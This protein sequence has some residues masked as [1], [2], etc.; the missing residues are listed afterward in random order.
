LS[1]AR[2]GG[3][4]R[5][6]PLGVA[7]RQGEGEVVEEE[8]VG[9]QPVLVAGDVADAAGDLELAAPGPG[10]PLLVDGE[11]DDALPVVADQGEH[12][13]AAGPAVLEVDGVD[14]APPRIGL[15]RPSDHGRVCRV[16][17]QRC[18]DGLLERLDGG[19][20]L[21]GLVAPLGEGDADIQ[22]MGPALDLTAGHPDDPLVVVADQQLLDPPRPL[23]VDALADEQRPRLLVKLRGADA[24]G[25]PGRLGGPAGAGDGVA[26]PGDQGRDVL[27]RGS[28]AAPDGVDPQVA[29]ELLQLLGHRSGLHRV[30]GAAADVE[31]QAG[32]GDAG[33][34][35]PGVLGEVPDRVPHRFGPGGAVEADHVDPERLEDRENGGDVGA[36]QHPAG[37]VQGHL[38]LD[39][40]AAPHDLERL[41]HAE[42]GRLH[43][44]DVLAGLDEQEVDAARQQ[45]LRLLAEGRHQVGEPQPAQARIAAGGEEPRGPHPAGDETRPVGA[46]VLVRQ[47]PG[48]TGGLLV[49]LPGALSRSPLGQPRWRRL[50]GAG[51]DHIGADLE[52]GAVNPLDQLGAVEHEAV[53]PPLQG[54]AAELL[55]R[56]LERLETGPHGTVVDQHPAIQRCEVGG[57]AHAGFLRGGRCIESGVSRAR[58]RRAARGGGL[59]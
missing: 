35:E 16:D 53:H 30:V 49:E 17:D 31:R 38:G 9:R 37:D 33:D 19:R 3:V 8:L 29:D 14:D 5:I 39:G 28:A 48:Q 55:G 27:R 40:D 58:L 46:G 15:Q 11:G 54:R 44:E 23:S 18:L 45:P 47:P 25:E 32:V 41:A 56:G 36:E 2:A 4:S 24:R 42:D 34:R 22:C 10:H 26:Q 43:L 1:T 6:D 52:E 20:H 50:E 59:R 57:V 7:R 21:L 51:L 13:I 12:R